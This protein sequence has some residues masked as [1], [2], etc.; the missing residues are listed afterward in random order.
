MCR[1]KHCIAGRR[2]LSV[3]SP[4]LPLPTPNFMKCKPGPRGLTREETDSCFLYGEQTHSCSEA[5]IF[6]NEIFFFPWK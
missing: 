2:L 3:L 6:S 5:R 1:R 4:S